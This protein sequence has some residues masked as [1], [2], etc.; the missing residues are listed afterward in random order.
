MVCHCSKNLWPGQDAATLQHLLRR[1][2]HGPQPLALLSTHTV[3]AAEAR[4]ACVV[5]DSAQLPGI[6]DVGPFGRKKAWCH[7][8][9][10]SRRCLH[11]HTADQVIRSDMRPTTETELV[12][13]L[14]QR[15]Q[16]G[17]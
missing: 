7:R 3:L 16:G 13:F 8:H 15:A 11:E 1:L 2:E 14:S 5:L 6:H 10:L 9:P 12:Q 17:N 4:H